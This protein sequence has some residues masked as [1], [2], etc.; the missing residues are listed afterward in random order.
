MRKYLWPLDLGLAVLAGII[1]ALLIVVVALDV[2]SRYVA[3][4]SFPWINDECASFLFLWM[5]AVGAALVTG[6]SGHLAIDT[7]VVRFPLSVQRVV[8]IGVLVACLCFVGALCY[9]GA[10]LAWSARSANSMLLELPMVWVQGS[11]PFGAAM[12]FIYYLAELVDTLS[13]RDRRPE[14]GGLVGP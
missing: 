11:I 2:I 14:E 9:Y 5:A 7:L 10:Q 6:R 13:G 12:M 3:I 8:R 1:T 4:R